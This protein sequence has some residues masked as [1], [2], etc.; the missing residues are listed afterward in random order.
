MAKA[1]G[2]QASERCQGGSRPARGG[3]KR[4]KRGGRG[5]L[6]VVAF[7]DRGGIKLVKQGEPSRAGEAGCGKAAALARQGDQGQHGGA[8]FDLICNAQRRVSTRPSHAPASS[9]HVFD[10]I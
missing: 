4:V 7:A 5:G 2:H 1:V 6:R 10:L 9:R 3:I 8:S